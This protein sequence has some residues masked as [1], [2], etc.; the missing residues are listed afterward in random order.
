MVSLVLVPL[1][2]VLGFVIDFGYMHFLKMSAQTAAEA[3]AQAA[4]IDFRSTTGGTSYTCGGGVVC[5]STQTSCPSGIS[6][7]TNSIQHG[8]MYAQAHGFNSLD[9]N[10]NSTGKNVTY[11]AGA[12]SVPPTASGITSAAYWVT[13]RVT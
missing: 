9:S 11:Q 8:C 10:G 2:G 7:P 12:S 3:A 6:S 5:A 1:F 13:F 4:I